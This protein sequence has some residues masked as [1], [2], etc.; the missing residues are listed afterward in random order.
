[1]PE[2]QPP[3]TPPSPPRR[4]PSSQ[5]GIIG[6]Q[7]E[8][9]P[10]YPQA[11]TPQMPG[12]MPGIPGTPAPPWQSAT[13]YQPPAAY[14]TP[15]AMPYDRTKQPP[16]STK[17]TFLETGPKRGRRL[18]SAIVVALIIVIIVLAGFAVVKAGWLEAPLSK[19]SGIKLPQWLP[20]GTTDTTPPVISEVKVSDITQTGAA[21]T[22]QTDEPATSQVMICDPAGSC[23][24]TAPNKALVTNH[25]VTLTDLKPNT[26]Y[27][28]T[29]A[30]MDARE[31]QQT[32]E[33]NFTTLSGAVTTQLQISGVNATQITDSSAIVNWVTDKPA[34]SQVEYGTTDAYGSTTQLDENLTASH[35]VTLAKLKPNTTYHFI[36]KS[37]GA[38]GSEVAFKDQ[39][40]TTRSTA[41]VTAEVGPEVGKRAP[42]LTLPTI[43]GKMVSLSNL[44][45]KIVVINFWTSR[46]QCRNQLSFIEEVYEN[47]PQ[48]DQL[49][50]L[51][52][53]VGE[54]DKDVQKATSELGLTF[55]VLLD[56]DQKVAKMYEVAS[57]STPVT[58][59][60]DSQGIIRDKV[61]NRTSTV[62]DIQDKL[63]SLQS[64]P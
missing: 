25:S 61:S 52:I 2:Q 30:S 24:W 44:Q 36:V 34:T 1:M 9:P 16:A 50:I 4:L 62:P 3:P 56:K 17:T 32:Y 53:N 40:F 13:D 37:K 39:T 54:S 22:W 51:A 20:I 38:D 28:I 29:T 57:T 6:P 35:I 47:W 45:G 23:T 33:G 58:F 42:S 19:V 8:Q 7:P 5:G 48:K 43:D 18:S 41:P 59:F 49:G 11:P 46:I 26:T 64:P 55:T 14:G 10:S 63:N 21:V 60:I 15:H 12:T 31:N 27:K